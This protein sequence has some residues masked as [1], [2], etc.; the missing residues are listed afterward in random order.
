MSFE[1]KPH[2]T[3]MYTIFQWEGKN[4]Q[5]QLIQGVRNA[6]CAAALKKELRDEGIFIIKLQAQKKP[7]LLI[8]QKIP[9]NTITFM[10]R[11]LAILLSAGFP[12]ITA[13]DS[14]VLNQVN[15][16]AQLLIMNIKNTVRNGINLAQALA[17][18]PAY[19]DQLTCALISTGEAT[20]Q[21]NIMLQRIV[22]HR[23]KMTAIKHKMLKILL[24]PAIVFIATIAI[25]IILL[26]IVIPQF[27]N[28]FANFNAPL[29]MITKLIITLSQFIQINGLMIFLFILVTPFLISTSY[30]LSK[31][32]QSLLQHLLLHFPLI[33]STLQKNIHARIARTLAT[34]L[35]S[36][37][38]LIESLR[39]AGEISAYKEYKKAFQS[40]A[41]AIK[42]G[43]SLHKAMSDTKLFPSFML[44]MIAIGEESATLDKIL[45]KIAE[46]YENQFDQT[47]TIFCTLIEPIIMIILAFIIGSMIIAIYLPIF[48][49]GSIL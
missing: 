30:R 5:G 13:L 20:G 39:H 3:T 34:T 15:I 19:F 14:I 31:K 48:K 23:E 29:P 9:Y 33:G 38:P 26:V 43:T 27:N 17:I 18:H 16:T 2:Q 28:L 8:K 21:L 46:C 7:L 42:S 1:N 47:I 22:T 25:T 44:Q 49:I 24:Y 41:L 32:I 37:L 10:L 11:Q 4:P 6:S 40:I 45:E 36:G 12:L 35:L